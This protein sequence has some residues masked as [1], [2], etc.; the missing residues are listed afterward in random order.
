MIR[1]DERNTKAKGIAAALSEHLAPG[2]VPEGV[3]VVIG[4]DGF[5]LRAIHELGANP[6]Y[7]GLN[8]GYMGFLLNDVHDPA[9]VAAQIRDEAFDV[10][11]VPRLKMQ[12][13]RADGST[14]EGRALNDVVL[15]RMSGQSSHLRVVVDGVE[16]VERM[17]CDGIIA[18]T[19]LGSTAY[20]FSAG[21][22][23]C[24]PELRL[25]Q[26]T[27]ICPHAPRL[28]TITLPMSAVIEVEVY[29]PERRH[30]RVVTDH[31]DYSAVTRVTIQD[32][33]RDVRVAWLEGRNPTAN[34]VRKLIHP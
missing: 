30:T 24:H 34:L 28:G 11:A 26:L 31:I 5:L 13:E 2:D 29:D 8:A 9:I 7:L 3:C 4:G 27:P 33:R 21:G 12:A 20:S 15:Q 18:A 10:A 17:S 32:A 25:I 6:V 19:A 22:P 23:A 16:V 14:F 1:V